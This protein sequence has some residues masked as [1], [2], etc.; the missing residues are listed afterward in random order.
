MKPMFQPLCFRVELLSSKRGSRFWS[1][2]FA[3]TIPDPRKWFPYCWPNK[4]Q[5]RRM[6]EVSTFGSIWISPPYTMQL[7][8]RCFSFSQSGM[9]V[10]WRLWQ[11]QNTKGPSSWCR[12]TWVG[13]RVAIGFRLGQRSRILW[14]LASMPS[15][16]TLLR[17]T[18]RSDLPTVQIAHS[19]IIYIY[20]TFVI[21]GNLAGTA[22]K[23]QTHVC[24]SWGF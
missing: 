17:Q 7:L 15:S 3:R 22:L 16:S 18:I 5:K 1:L 19:Y 14:T 2:I 21:L 24:K 10:P 6:N 12:S 13:R 23:F 20:I 8:S 11:S 4:I 9:L